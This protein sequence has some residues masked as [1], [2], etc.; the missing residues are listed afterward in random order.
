VNRKLVQ[1]KGITITAIPGDTIGLRAGLKVE[2]DIL[3][4]K[5]LQQPD[6]GAIELTQER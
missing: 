3:G 4:N 1:N 6:L 2:K 5:I